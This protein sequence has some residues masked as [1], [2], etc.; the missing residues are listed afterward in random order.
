MLVVSTRLKYIT[1]TKIF[2]PQVAVLDVQGL[3]TKEIFGC[4]FIPT[5]VEPA[6][7]QAKIC[8]SGI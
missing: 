7:N 1:V 2:I 6:A 4:I 8:F 3:K 5:N